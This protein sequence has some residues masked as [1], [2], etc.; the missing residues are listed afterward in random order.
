MGLGVTCRVVVRPGFSSFRPAAD[1]PAR[2]L[3]SGAACAVAAI[4]A[5]ARSGRS[6]G[7]FRVSVHSTR[8]EVSGWGSPG[9]RVSCSTPRRKRL[10]D[11]LRAS[12][13]RLAV[14]GR[15]RLRA[16]GPLEP[17][18]RP[19]GRSGGPRS[20]S[21]PAAR[22]VPAD[23]LR[24][25]SWPPPPAATPSASAPFSGLPPVSG[26]GHRRGEGIPPPQRRTCATSAHPKN[27]PL[28]RRYTSRRWPTVAMS[29]VR[30]ACSTV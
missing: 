4:I 14:L 15:L 10:L 24:S 18:E 23:P 13:G 6:V 5:A 26:Q 20:P 2:R 8:F 16:P 12:R 29:T 22:G 9:S 11:G 1:P 3:R 7:R 28:H 25:G 19:S 27:P 17:P 21:A 30:V